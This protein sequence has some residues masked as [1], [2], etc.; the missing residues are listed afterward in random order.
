MTFFVGEQSIPVNGR[1][2]RIDRRHS[3][4]K[5]FRRAWKKFFMAELDASDQLT[6]RS[7]GGVKVPKL[8]QFRKRVIPQGVG[9]AVEFPDTATQ[10]LGMLEFVDH[11]LRHR[12][13]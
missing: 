9:I 8:F 7:Q 2:G 10:D 6:K 1:G 3:L 4:D 5:R 12:L 13:L 11:V